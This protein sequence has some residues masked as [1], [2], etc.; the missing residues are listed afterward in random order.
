MASSARLGASTFAVGILWRAVL[1]GGL[2]FV[3]VQAATREL[4][5]TA[6][7]LGGLI[8]LVAG[9]LARAAGATDRILAQF[10]DGVAAQGYEWPRA[11]NQFA[12]FGAAMACAQGRIEAVRGARQQQIDFLESLVET[13]LAALLVVDQ[14][15]G[16]LHANRAAMALGFCPGAP[17]GLS[18]SLNAAASR[19]IV[20]LP[21]GG[22][23]L[24]QVSLF[25]SQAMAGRRLVSLQTLAGDLELVEMKAQSDL[26]RILAHEMMN[27]LTPIASLSESLLRRLQDDGLEQPVLSDALEVISR[28][29]AGLLSF[30]ER[31]RRVAD[32]TAG[33]MTKTSAGE[34]VSRLERLVA[35]LMTAAG[36]RLVCEA[37]APIRVEAD[38]DL[39]EQ[40]LLNLLINAL[41]ATAPEADPQVNFRCVADETSISFLISDSGPGLA[42][43]EAAFVPFYTTK[44]HGSGVGLTLARQIATA[45]GGR[46]EYQRKDGP[47]TFVLHIPRGE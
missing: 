30:V 15:G 5:A 23:A 6:L 47:T 35:P 25:R 46:L 38:V 33:A 13:S 2:A 17:L 18:L 22:S 40:A 19:K 14:K 24:M 29:S 1:I 41:D 37:P 12:D 4:Y 7:V 26:V 42:D 16:V 39:L 28:R 44:P 3:A 43:S 9:D 11:P 8:L 31:Y 20:E 10:I 21:R 34:V 36:V 45:H 32:V 27:S